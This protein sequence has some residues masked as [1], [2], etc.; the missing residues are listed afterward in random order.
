MRHVLAGLFG[1][2]LSST[3][4]AAPVVTTT[5]GGLRGTVRAGVEAFRGVP[6]AAAPVGERRW[7]APQPLAR[8]QGLRD[9]SRFGPACAQGIA[10]AWGPYSAEFIAQ[11][12]ISEDCLTLNLWKPAGKRRGLPVLVFVHGGAFQGGAGS[13]PVYDGAALARRGAVVVT[14]NY[15][16]GVFG[17]FAHPALRGEDQGGGRD[18]GE[19]NYGLLDQLAAL[20]WVRANAARFGGDG[21][22]VTLAGESAGAASVNDLMV[23][24]LAKGLFARAVSFS[25]PSMAVDVGTMADGER[26]GVALAA[27]LGAADPAALRAVP[28]DALIAA[29]RMAPVEGGGPPPLVWRPHLDGAVLPYDPVRPDGPLAVNVPL[30]GGYNAAEMI[31]LS[32]NTPVAFEQAVRRRYGTFAERLLALYPH[33]SDAEA[34]AANGLIARDRYLA[35][36]LLWS[37]AR[38]RAS[39]QPVHAYLHDHTYPP[40]RGQAAY[41]AFHSSELAYVFG[42]LVG[43]RTFTAADRAVVRQWQDRLLAFMRSGNPGWPRVGKDTT[44]VMALGDR[45]GLRAAVSTPARLAAFRDYAAGGGNLGLM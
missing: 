7:R 21:A 36:L 6:Y 12:P 13:L 1:L 32:V 45:P 24:P 33:A 5:G 3:A 8:W 39:G 23:S 19:G 41:G 20:R 18:G 28:M 27:R 30:L 44:R 26:D 9:A 4:L 38:V 17:F 22:N 16:V 25:G 2:A 29:S 43:D 15:R 14:I 10:G 42:N 11:P 31:D 37:R 40:V 34:V 35:G